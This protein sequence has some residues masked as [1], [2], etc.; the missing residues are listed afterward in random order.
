MAREDFLRTNVPGCLEILRSGI[1]I[2]TKNAWMVFQKECRLFDNV[3]IQVRTANLKPMSL[4]LIF[5]F[6][7]KASGAMVGYGGEKLVFVNTEGKPVPVPP[8]IMEN[9]KRFLTEQVQKL[10]GIN[11]ERISIRCSP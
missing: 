7:N 6:K 8:P 3:E 1:R 10:Q 11:P 4:E 9:A 2:V 5:T